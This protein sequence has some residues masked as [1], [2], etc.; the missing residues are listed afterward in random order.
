[1]TEEE[2]RQVSRNADNSVNWNYPY[3][4]Q[5]VDEKWSLDTWRNHLHEN[6]LEHVIPNIKA[7]NEARG[8]ITHSGPASLA[9]HEPVQE[10]DAAPTPP[11]GTTPNAD[12]DI[13]F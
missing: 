11:T 4:S 13:P 5:G 3:I 10:D 12:D 9:N 2:E 6:V 1:M 7:S 8:V